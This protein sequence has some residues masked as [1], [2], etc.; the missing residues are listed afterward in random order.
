MDKIIIEGGHNLK[1]VVRISGSKNAALPV[2][3]ST[4]LT[5]DKCLI[6]NVP[7]LKDID[8]TLE[9]LEFFGKKVKRVKDTIEISGKIASVIAPYE[10]IKRMRASFLV[11]GPLLARFKKARVALPGGCAIGVRPVDIHLEGFSKLGADV[12]VE[13]G[14][15][16]MDS[17]NLKPAY[18][19]L[20]FPSVGATENMMMTASLIDG[21]TVI[22]NV[23]HEPEIVDLADFLSKLGV[24]IQGAGTDTVT[25]HGRNKLHGACHRV[26]PDRIETGTYLI[27]GAISGGNIV[28]DDCIP[29]DVKT[30]ISKL[31]CAGF[32]V[33]R[34][35]NSI[36]ITGGRG[37]KIKPVNVTTETY[38]GFPTDLQAQWM[39]L[40]C[41]ADGRSVVREN[42]FEN[43]FLHVGELQRFGAKLR[44]KGDSVI[45]EGKS[46]LSSAPVMVSDLR[47]GAALVLAGLVAEGKTVISRVYHLDRG[48]EHL[49]K[50]LQKL[51]A[52]I[53][54]NSD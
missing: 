34:E 3:F 1:G 37:N 24:K 32:K 14:Y 30:V 28:V 4:L 40:M 26:I 50:K 43:R 39:A 51:G 5:D 33:K 18:L 9:L 29:E 19:H 48:Y 23:A 15:V 46:K 31:I 44:I 45:I 52:K 12:K 8:A 16:V 35:N 20:R 47:A 36:H 53:H 27:A 6:A 7:D 2:L 54:R 49:E 42:I 17:R 11:S 21:R 10:L 13:K 25:V 41:I 22:H 38:P